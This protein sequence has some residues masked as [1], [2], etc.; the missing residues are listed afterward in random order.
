[1]GRLGHN[2]TTYTLKTYDC[3]ARRGWNRLGTPESKRLLNTATQELKQL[4]KENK[5]DCSQ[6]FPHGLKLTESTDYSLW[7]A[8]KKIKQVKKPSPSLRISQGTWANSILEKIKYNNSF[9][10]TNHLRVYMTLVTSQH[11][12]AI[13]SHLQV[14]HNIDTKHLSHYQG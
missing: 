6:T 1:M 5:N 2:A 8:T 14:K 4:L 7:K 9:L 3:P 11:V 10:A 12:L 13:L